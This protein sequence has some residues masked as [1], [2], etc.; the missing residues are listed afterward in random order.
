M[1]SDMDRAE[2][3]GDR[4]SPSGVAVLRFM[5]TSLRTV[6]Q[7]WLS[8]R[9]LIWRTAPGRMAGARY[10]SSGQQLPGSDM[11]CSL[12]DG[13]DLRPMIRGSARTVLLA[14]LLLEQLSTVSFDMGPV[15]CG[16][17]LARP[18]TGEGDI[19]GDVVGAA[20]RSSVGNGGPPQRSV[21][22][23]VGAG[24]EARLCSSG[25]CRR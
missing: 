24:A 14:L 23:I 2:R 12:L 17:P 5:W 7:M 3:T 20:V 22:G 4:P 18:A 11:T 8:E 10:W 21:F 1:P 6:G 9:S 19:V 25:R 16:A 13:R 15:Q